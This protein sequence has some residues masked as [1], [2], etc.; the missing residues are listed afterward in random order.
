MVPTV[1]DPPTDLVYIPFTYEYDGA[2]LDAAVRTKQPLIAV[3]ID[4]EPGASSVVVFLFSD[5]D[6]QIILFELNRIQFGVELPDLSPV[7]DTIREFP[8]PLDLRLY[9]SCLRVGIRDAVQ[10]VQPPK[11]LAVRQR[12]DLGVLSGFLNW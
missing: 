6:A 7:L 2:V 9:F 1:F 5:D 3:A 11:D 8:Q 4:T 12:D 10:F